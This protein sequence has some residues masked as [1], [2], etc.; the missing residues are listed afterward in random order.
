[1]NNP[2]FD[3]YVYDDD[4]CYKQ[5]FEEVLYLRER[6]SQL[7]LS[8]GNLK[9]ML[10]ETQLLKVQLEN[11]LLIHTQKEKPSQSKSKRTYVRKEL[12]KEMKGV[13]AY[14]LENKDNEDI[15]KTIR[16]K[17]N[18]V[19]YQIDSKK[20]LPVQLIKMECSK[21][22]YSLNEHEQERYQNKDITNKT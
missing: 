11:N 7:E 9:K 21:R 10:D 5:L 2:L 22:Y 4:I 12:S 15:S 20:Q 17:M 19:G 18:E 13:C 6:V 3:T 8:N 16:T 1:M 14:Y